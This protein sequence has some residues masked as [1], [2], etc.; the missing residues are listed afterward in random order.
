MSDLIRSIAGLSPPKTRSM[1]PEPDG[2][3][4]RT[5]QHIPMELPPDPIQFAPEGHVVTEN[6]FDSTNPVI[7]PPAKKPNPA[8]QQIQQRVLAQQAARRGR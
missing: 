5:P 4:P 6:P 2:P 7:A 8:Q 3:F 1:P